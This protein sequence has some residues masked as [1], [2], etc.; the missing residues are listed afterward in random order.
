L[1]APALTADLLHSDGKISRRNK[2]GLYIAFA[3]ATLFFMFAMGQSHAAATDSI[4][5]TA[6][7]ANGYTIQLP[8]DT[9]NSFNNVQINWGDGTTTT[10]ANQTDTVDMSHKYTTVGATPVSEPITV[11]L[12]ATGQL[13]QF[14]RGNNAWIAGA[15]F[16]TSVTFMN[17]S[18][19]TSWSG[20][21]YGAT[22]LISVPQ[23][24][25]GTSAT[26][27]DFSYMFDGASAFN[28]VNVTSW[29]TV[30][31]S[32]MQ[33]MFASATTFNQ[34]IGTWNTSS[35]TTMKD[36]FY[37]AL[38]FNQDI[39]TWDTHLVTNFQEMFRQAALFN[40]G[41]QPM[42]TNGNSWKMSAANSAGYMFRDDPVFNQPVVGWT[43][44]NGV[45]LSFMFYNDAAFNQSLNNE[46]CS[47][48]ELHVLRRHVIQQWRTIYEHQ[49]KYME[50]EQCSWLRQHV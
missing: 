21:F 20:A 24:I 36:M 29:N 43:F 34:A 5:L 2:I 13:K 44:A 1:S 9:G 28:S 7:V 27:Y 32:N 41:G 23:N 4:D 31:V 40:D 16:I 3:F 37:N 14:G 46:R 15:A 19:I 18:T 48:Y 30:S 49:R 45:D 12:P 22:S 25:F 39:H 11:S 26:P 38:N 17:T 50:C 47:W 6:S 8:L 33:Y 42:S 35:V 10:V